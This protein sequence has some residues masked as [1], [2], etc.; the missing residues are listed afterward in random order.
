M[1]RI[2]TLFAAIFAMS[3][4]MNAQETV[5]KTFDFGDFTGIRA[6]FIH[7]VHVTEG[8][9]DKI[10]VTCPEK[11]AS[12]LD[13]SVSNG[14]LNL[15]IDLPNNRGKFNNRG[16]EIIVKVQMERIESL[17]LSGAAELTPQGSFR[18]ND[19]EIGLSGASKIHGSFNLKA[20]KLDID[21]SGASGCS[22][23]GAFP[24]VEA[25]I[26]GAS[27]LGLNA[28]TKTLAVEASGASGF[29]FTGKSE[30]I[31]IECSGAS[32]AKLNGTTNDID[33]KCSGASKVDAEEM[34]AENAKASA[35]GASHI[36]VYADNRLNLQ[37]SGGSKIKYF[38][39]AKDLRMTNRSI[40]RGE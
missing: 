28:Y 17:K 29:D 39:E 12:Y 11:Y 16:E 30:N 35:S 20:D 1:K 6:G 2:L 23:N 21:L 37:T 25:D 15:N 7:H 33:I 27:K 40:T 13:Y 19:A 36:R 22:I 5:K 31:E 8:K 24:E 9:S 32:E 14:V 3:V 4:C 18:A 38:G 26:S 34:R 10:E